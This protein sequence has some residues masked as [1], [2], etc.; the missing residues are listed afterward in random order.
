MKSANAL[1]LSRKGLAQTRLAAVWAQASEADKAPFV[2]CAEAYFA[3]HPAQESSLEATTG[4]VD[5]LALPP[6]ALTESR[7]D[8]LN[9]FQ[10]VSLNEMAEARLAARASR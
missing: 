6:L 7:R 8:I 5:A 2:S 3:G 1:T 4:L 9:Y 10:A